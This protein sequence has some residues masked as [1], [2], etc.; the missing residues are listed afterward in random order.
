[1]GADNMMAMKFRVKDRNSQLKN[2]FEAMFDED[3][4][5]KEYLNQT[6]QNR[7]CMF[8]LAVVEP[9]VYD[10]SMTYSGKPTSSDL[11]DLLCF[12]LPYFTEE[13]LNSHV[14]HYS[15][16][17]GEY[18]VAYVFNSG[19]IYRSGCVGNRDYTRDFIGGVNDPSSEEQQWG[20]PIARWDILQQ[21]V[22]EPNWWSRDEDA[23]FDFSKLG[24]EIKSDIVWE[25]VE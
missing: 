7:D 8:S 14:A 25:C 10:I 13:Q 22:E 2:F 1:M 21:P 19:K 9:D 24:E 12:F 6:M 15:C 4:D 18:N 5:N 17:W 16:D 23:Y 3:I 20:N 11:E